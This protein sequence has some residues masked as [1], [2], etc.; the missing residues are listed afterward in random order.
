MPACPLHR[1]A[2]APCPLRPCDGCLADWSERAGMAEC[3]EVSRDEAEA[4]ATKWLREQVEREERRGL[5]M[6]LM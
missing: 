5:Q 1:P 6:E 4:M 3:R 2:S